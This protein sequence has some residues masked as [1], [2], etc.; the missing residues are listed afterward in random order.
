MSWTPNEVEME[1]VLSMEASE[2]YRHWIK[3]VADQGAVWSLWKEGGWALAGDDSGRE[4]VPAWPHS[5]YAILCAAEAW[6][7]FEPQAIALDVWLDH[8]L[9][10]IER[11]RRLVAVFPTPN[12]QGLVIEPRRLEQ[13]LRLEL[14]NYE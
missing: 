2:R 10:G 1:A 6:A 9:P 14:A 13:D 12:D 3:K 7:G 4:L 5:R 11:D 8:W